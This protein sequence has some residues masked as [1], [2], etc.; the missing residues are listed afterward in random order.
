M[1]ADDE[2]KE[3]VKELQARCAGKM[4][5]QDVQ[6]RCATECAKGCFVNWELVAMVGRKKGEEL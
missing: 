6:A 4:C 3:W 2:V 1:I 5:R